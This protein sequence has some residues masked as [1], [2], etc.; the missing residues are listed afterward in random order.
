MKEWDWKKY[1]QLVMASI[2]SAI[3]TAIFG[4]VILVNTTQV[5]WSNLP[6]GQNPEGNLPYLSSY[7]FGLIVMVCGIV[8]TIIFYFVIGFLRKR[9]K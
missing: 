6:L 8:L 4:Y 1:F 3:V 5:D 7:H 2:I 9:K